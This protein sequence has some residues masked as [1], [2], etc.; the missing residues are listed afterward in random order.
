MEELVYNFIYGETFI[1]WSL[2]FNAILLFCLFSP[3]IIY[4]IHRRF[5]I[6]R[7]KS[8]VSKIIDEITYDNCRFREH[9]KRLNEEVDYLK[10]NSTKQDT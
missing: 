9:I 8:K 6:W 5:F 2:G 3:S 7:D 10:N 4:F 1:L